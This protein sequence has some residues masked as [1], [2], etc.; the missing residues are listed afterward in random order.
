VFNQTE[1]KLHTKQ[2]P[3][4]RAKWIV[5]PN[6]FGCIVD[7]TVFASAQQRFARFPRHKSDAE[8][9]DDLKKLYVK[10][11]KLT[12][13]LM[14]RTELRHSLGIACATTYFKRF[15]SLTR[16]YQMAGIEPS[17]TCRER[18][19]TNAQR[20]QLMQTLADRFPD[21]IRLV[22][23]KDKYLLFRNSTK[24]V[25][26]ICRSFKIKNGERRW[27][28]GGCDGTSIVL[29][30]NLNE[31]NSDVEWLLLLPPIAAES[32]YWL[33]RDSPMLKS[34]IHVDQT[35]FVDSV[36]RFIEVCPMRGQ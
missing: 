5:V 6:A 15:G 13:P 10:M 33:A 7:P 4:P 19:R 20:R 23:G 18:G 1:K 12:L 3:T 36:A 29:A 28:M 24:L 11:G 27:M 14:R 32:R 9:I 2:R 25:I 26:R 31:Q 8:M 35:T 16:I 34:G 30:A 22:P 21:D 17:Q